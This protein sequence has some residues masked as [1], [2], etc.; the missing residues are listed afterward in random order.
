M[1]RLQLDFVTIPEKNFGAILPVEEQILALPDAL[2]VWLPAPTTQNMV[3]ESGRIASWIGRKNGR[4]LTHATPARRPRPEAGLLRMSSDIQAPEAQ[5]DLSGAAIGQQN[6]FTMAVH[7]RIHPEQ[8]NVDNQY[9][10]GGSSPAGSMARLAYRFTSGN[11]YLRYQTNDNAL[12]HDVALPSDW[13]G[14]VGVVVV[15]D[16]LNIRMDLS[17][18]TTGSR[19]LTVPFSLQQFMVGNAATLA[20]AGSLRGYIGNLGLWTRAMTDAQRALLMRWVS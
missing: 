5:L 20:G 1:A 7:A 15:I 17:V 12:N 18:G 14:I 8:I 4:T 11:R 3:I 19:A 16:G 9:L 13:N 10:I 6:A 2:D